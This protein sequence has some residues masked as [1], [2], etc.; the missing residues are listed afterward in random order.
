MCGYLCTTLWVSVGIP[1]GYDC[2]LHAVTRRQICQVYETGLPQSALVSKTNKITMCYTFN[3]AF[4][5]CNN[6]MKIMLW[7]DYQD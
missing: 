6:V 2:E 7:I 5:L 3:Y 1:S 4:M